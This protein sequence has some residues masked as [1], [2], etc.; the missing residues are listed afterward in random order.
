ME[1]DDGRFFMEDLIQQGQ[2]RHNLTSLFKLRKWIRL[3]HL[4][5]GFILHENVSVVF[6]QPG[7]MQF[8]EQGILCMASD[9]L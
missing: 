1:F 8:D 3:R 9:S 7:V 4:E 2:G 5:R 6:I